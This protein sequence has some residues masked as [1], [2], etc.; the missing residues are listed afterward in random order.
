MR[1]LV[2]DDDPNARLLLEFYLR[3][4]PLQVDY[5]TDGLEALE[6]VRTHDI[7]IVVSDIR[8]PG[9]TG[10]ELLRTLKSERPDIPVLLM[11]AHSSVDDVVEMMKQGADDYI[12]K[13]FSKDVFLHRLNKLVEALERRRENARLKGEL[14]QLKERGSGT[15]SA[16]VGNSPSLRAVMARLPLVAKTDAPVMILGE[17]G[18]G[19]EM[20]ANAIHAESRRSKGRMVA[21]NCGALPDTL[22]ESELFGYKRGAFT[23]AHRD[24]PGL[25]ETAQG[26]TLFLDEIGD[27]SLPVQVKLLRFLQT[28]EYKPLGSPQTLKA[29]VRIISATHRDLPS[30]IKQGRFREDLFYRLNIV[31][32]T[33]PPLRDRKGDIPILAAHFLR[34]FCAEHSKELDGFS[35]AAMA[36]MEDHRFPG[37][38]R[39][40]ENRIHQAVVM[41][42]GRRIE[43]ADLGL[44][45][46]RSAAPSGDHPPGTFKDAKGRMINAFEATYAERIL[47]ES[48]GNITVA[49]K[50][51]G[52]DRKSFFLLLRKHGLDAQAFGS[53]VGRPSRAGEP[54]T[55]LQ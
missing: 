18:T 26:G 28:R 40:L 45:T 29:D 4:E 6:R 16:I 2:A 30:F 12:A 1:V 36:I 17:S 14:E 5:V 24:T 20:V 43:P 38:I 51:A 42:T 8:M 47:K 31:S 39:E 22:L 35:E 23:D 21:V 13:P 44:G 53:K 10:D 15:P 27:V 50:K 11:T 7:D 52:L 34:R 37:N 55:E 41:C 9:V 33:L 25:V 32:L 19:K 54:G 3:D 49:A 46:A 48:G